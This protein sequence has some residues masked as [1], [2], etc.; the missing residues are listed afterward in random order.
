MRWVYEFQV[1]AMAWT[2]W[3]RIC[4]RCIP[5]LASRMR[6]F[7]SSSRTLDGSGRKL[8]LQYPQHLK[9]YKLFFLLFLFSFGPLLFEGLPFLARRVRFMVSYNSFW[10]HLWLR[11]LNLKSSLRKC[12]WKKC[13]ESMS[14][15]QVVV[16]KPCCFCKPL[17]RVTWK[18]WP[19]NLWGRDS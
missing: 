9:R 4:K 2:I 5:K 1:A 17:Q 3:R 13:S 14:H 11:V 16:L 15:C 10:K 19:R 7:S 8:Q 12:A 18:F 6:A